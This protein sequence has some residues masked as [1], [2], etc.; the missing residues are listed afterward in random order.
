[1]PFGPRDSDDPMS[2]CAA[3]NVSLGA[4]S[5]VHPRDKVWRLMASDAGV[6]A[7]KTP[8]NEWRFPRS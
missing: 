3:Q 1:M 2:Y 4:E 7:E 8:E 5:D 6:A